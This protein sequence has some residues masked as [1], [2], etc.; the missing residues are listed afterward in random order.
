M[1]GSENN[2]P[3][4]IVTGVN[5]Q[6]GGELTRAAP[7]AAGV[8]AC[9]R[10]DLDLTDPAS[11]DRVIE[12]YQPEWIIN[13]AAYTAVDRAE[14]EP[15]EAFRV[16]ADG[17]RDLASAARRSGARLIHISTDFV[18]D[19][20]RGRAYEPGDEP[21]PMNAYGRSKLAGERYV[22]EVL[23]DQATVIRTAWVYARGGRNFVNT[24]LRLMTERDEVQVVADQVGSPT[25]ARSLAE[26]IW[27][28]VLRS[29]APGGIYHFTDA[30]VASWYDFA[31]AVREEG[32]AAGILNDPAEV[33]PV[34]TE[35]FPTPAGRPP[36]S[37]LACRLP[38]GLEDYRRRHWRD[39]LRRMLAQDD[40]SPGHE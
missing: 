13:A 10:S 29:P 7:H 18:F 14:S 2:A 34:T 40:G 16:N 5:G 20:E 4:V 23:G 12:Q 15:D 8:K 3:R 28:T 35:A 38:A 22:R 33:V 24:M 9:S 11:V 31:T 30:G 21:S 26:M 39:A 19:G 6:L 27:R 32:L 36:F 25:W 17:P 1:A 37:V